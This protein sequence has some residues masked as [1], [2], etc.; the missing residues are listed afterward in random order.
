MEAWKD[1]QM[2]LRCVVNVADGVQPIFKWMRESGNTTVKER[3]K[4]SDTRQLSV[5]KLY[6]HF[7][8]EFDNYICVARTETTTKSHK[9]TIRRLCTYAGTFIIIIITLTV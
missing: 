6:P 8:N 1:H 3:A 4:Q 2:T 5:L 7:E 9:V